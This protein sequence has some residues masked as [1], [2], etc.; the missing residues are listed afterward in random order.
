MAYSGVHLPSG[1]DVLVK[2][3]AGSWVDLGVTMEGGSLEATYETTKITGS[4][5]EKIL[6]AFRQFSVS[7]TFTLAQIK[8]ENIQLLMSGAT[9]YSA[10]AATTEDKTENIASGDWAY[11]TVY[12]FEH[13]SEDGSKPTSIVIENPSGTTLTENTDYVIVES[14]G[15]WGYYILSGATAPDDTADL[16]IAY[17]IQILEKTEL[18]MGDRS[19]E[20][21]PRA[22]KI[23]KNLGT[24]SSPKYFGVEIYSATNENGLTLSFPRYDEEDITTLE[25]Q[26]TGDLDTTRGDLDKLLRVFDETAA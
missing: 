8:L 16:D 18:T 13:Q 23:Q 4:Q 25:V 5:A 3:D 20:V 2:D 12:S 24:D 17:T 9:S 6:T 14:G 21:A 10:T 26:L 22:F 1:Y 11:D 15:Q 7:S 19:V